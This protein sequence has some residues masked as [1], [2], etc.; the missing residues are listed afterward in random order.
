MCDPRAAIN[1]AKRAA[2]KTIRER[3]EALD[4][5]SLRRK[6]AAVARRLW[7]TSWWREAEW[8]FAYVATFGEVQTQALIARAYREGKR[9]AIPRIEGEDLAFY[10]YEGRT[11]GLLPNQFGILEPD[12]VWTRV[13]PASL[14]DRRLLV[15]APGLGFDRHKRRLGRGKGFY[16]R[17]LARVRAAGTRAVAVGLAFSEQLEE[18]IPVSEQDQALDGLVTDREVFT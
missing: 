1:A 2:R 7:A 5:D 18:C 16:D 3:V 17:F 13:E 15:L 6:S 12:P 8:V 11:R 10:R 14:S 9:V 4:A